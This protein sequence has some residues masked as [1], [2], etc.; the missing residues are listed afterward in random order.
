MGLTEPLDKIKIY[1]TFYAKGKLQEYKLKLTEIKTS[2]K[3]CPHN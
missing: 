2:C 3:T 1:F